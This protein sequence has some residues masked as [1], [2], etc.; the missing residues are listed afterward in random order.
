MFAENTSVFTSC[1]SEAQNE[2][3]AI[4]ALAQNALSSPSASA[5]TF[6]K[7]QFF[8]YFKRQEE[9][10]RVRMNDTLANVSQLLFGSDE[11]TTASTLPSIPVSLGGSNNEIKIEEVHSTTTTATSITTPAGQKTNSVKPNTTGNSFTR[12]VFNSSFSREKSSFSTHV[13]SG[14]NGLIRRQELPQGGTQTQRSRHCGGV[15]VLQLNCSDCPTT[16][17]SDAQLKAHMQRAHK[18]YS[19]RCL[20]QNCRYSFVSR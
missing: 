8:K 17:S 3:S 9:I 1:F 15:E 20:H 4:T 12:P 10:E 2:S 13:A 7:L 14:K 6:S 19:F 5:P 16:V 18:F 11:P